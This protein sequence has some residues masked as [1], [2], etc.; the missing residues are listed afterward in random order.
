[1]A[2]EGEHR[3]RGELLGPLGAGL[4]LVVVVTHVQ[5]HKGLVVVICIAASGLVAIVPDGPPGLFWHHSEGVR[6]RGTAKE[7]LHR[8]RWVLR[9]YGHDA[10]RG[11]ARVDHAGPERIELL[12]RDVG[13]SLLGYGRPVHR[14]HDPSLVSVQEDAGLVVVRVSLLDKAGVR[15]EEPV[16]RGVVELAGGAVEEESNRP[17]TPVEPLGLDE[18]ELIVLHHWGA[19][20]TKVARE[21]HHRLHLA[22][23]SAA[24]PV[25]PTAKHH[26]A[27]HDWILVHVKHVAHLILIVVGDPADAHLVEPLK[28][29]GI[30]VDARVLLILLHHYPEVGAWRRIGRHRCKR[31][32]TEG[33]PLLR[34]V[35]LRHQAVEHRQRAP[36]RLVCVVISLMVLVMASVAGMCSHIVWFVH[37]AGCV[38]GRVRVLLLDYV[39]LPIGQ[40]RKPH[41]VPVPRAAFEIVP[42]Q[43]A[44]LAVVK[45]ATVR[46]HDVL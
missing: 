37:C 12:N 22:A 32:I 40:H 44:D 19:P 3:V 39:V 46:N 23:L 20:E 8:H 34:H 42:G 26:L 28:A 18:L 17:V 5:L 9:L 35:E 7:F 11:V 14:G 21:R 16:L 41:S 1:M 30:L 45:L 38:A 25:P 10:P 15:L 13:A 31:K 2:H 6:V 33:K 24:G 36:R 4:L 43:E 29:R 27:L